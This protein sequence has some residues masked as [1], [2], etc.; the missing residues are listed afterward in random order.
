MTP[1]QLAQQR[2]QAIADLQAQLSGQVD[3]AQR[4][5]YERLLAQLQAIH[6]DPTLLP[7]LLQQYT[8][9]VLVPLAAAYG[10]AMLYLPGYNVSYFEQLEVAD[11][12][13]L[14]APLAEFLAQRLG[15]DAAG[16]VVPGGYLS[17]IAADTT[18]SRQVLSYAYQAQ[19]SGVGLEGYKDG[20]NALVLGGDQAAQGVVQQLYRDSYD[21]FNQNDRALQTIAARELGLKAAIY[22]GGLIDS[23]RPFCVARNGQC[24][25]DF[26]IAKFGTKADPYGG[27]AK[28]SEGYFSGKPDPYDP[29]TDCG[30]YHCRH[31]WHYVPNVV[32]LRMRPDLKETEKG[33]LYL[34]A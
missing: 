22:Q 18:I 11:Y 19:A 7:V 8:N 6:A 34:A 24:F 13:R 9:T 20:L 31:G 1:E 2:L 17:T 26:E 33:E 29:L 28:K 4:Q 10:Q 14:R 32:A 25:V 15:L 12:Q 21:T 16:N 27:Y 23:S 30:G 5:L 3:A